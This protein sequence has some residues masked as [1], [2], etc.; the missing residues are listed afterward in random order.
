[1]SEVFVPLGGAGGKSRGD[2]VD[3]DENYTHLKMGDTADMALPLPAGVYKKF[4]PERADYELLESI[5]SFGDG[6]NAVIVLEEG[7]LKKMTLEAFGIAS[8]TNFS[9]SMYAHRQ[10]R[11]TWAKSSEGLWSGVHFVFKY[12]SMPSN[13]N[14]GFMVYDSADVHYETARLEERELFVRAFNYVTVRDGRWYDEGAVSARITVSGISGSVT[15]STGAGVWTVPDNVYKIRYIVV[16]QGGDGGQG[17]GYYVPGGG[18][19]GGYFNSGYMNVTPGQN[20]NWIIPSRVRVAGGV[21]PSDVTDYF[22]NGAHLPQCD[23]VFGDIRVEHGRSPRMANAYT[24]KK[25]T[26]WGCGGNGGSGGAAFGGSHGANGNDGNGY[27]AIISGNGRTNKA[28]AKLDVTPGVGQ[29]TSTTGFNGV[30]YSTGGD[31]GLSTHYSS[32]GGDG[33][34]GLGNGGHGATQKLARLSESE[35]GGKGGNGC[36]YIAWGSLMN[37][38]S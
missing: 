13:E 7:L 2:V 18:G 10:V 27:V 5:T 36:I 9:L 23:T 25:L 4:K 37:D 15:L 14:D 8:I 16:G 21:V 19:G 17:N 20:I 34:D 30:L 1:M 33:T 3:M 24:D 31:S 12:G 35:N 28:V 22:I 29:H 32:R 38:G 11:L 26:H 6:K